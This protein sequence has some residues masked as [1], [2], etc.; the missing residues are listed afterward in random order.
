MPSSFTPAW[1][2]NDP[3][4]AGWLPLD[5][6]RQADRG[7]AVQAATAHSM[8]AGLVDVIAAQQARLPA[9]QARDRA[10]AALRNPDAMA[11]VTGQQV[12]LFLGP[13]YTLYK[14]ASTVRIAR[15][16]ADETGLPCVPIFWLQNE[17]HD[18]E[19]I[20]RIELPTD[21][22]PVSLG[23]ADTPGDVLADADDAR[24]W[25]LVSVRARRLGG[26]VEQLH[27]QLGPHL[28]GLPCGADV[29][30]LLA[31][32]YQSDATLSAAFAGVLAELFA[33]QGLLIIDPSDAALTPFA[34]PVHRKA[35]GDAAAMAASLGE[36]SAALNRAGVAVQVHVRPDSPLSFWHCGDRDGPRY[37]LEPQGAESWRLCGSQATV[38]RST[39][40]HDLKHRPERFSTSALLRP[41]LQDSWLPT[42]AYVGGPG[43]CAYFAQL[44][45]LY[46]AFERQMPLVVPRAR[47]ALVDATAR[48]LAR[49][50]GLAPCDAQDSE[51]ALLARLGAKRLEG[52]G[53]GDDSVPQDLARSL[54]EPL[55]RQL[56]RLATD[57]DGWDPGLARSTRRL[58]KALVAQIEKFA[59]RYQRAVG[60][61]DAT[62]RQRLARLQGLLSPDGLPQE[63]RYGFA[64]FAARV[65]GCQL[66]AQ[67]VAHAEPWQH[68]LKWLDL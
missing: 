10:V 2:A 12:G 40:L 17:D 66:V 34:A 32:H 19:E 48:R 7:R 63:R 61:R 3:A 65:G 26:E 42:V 35:F 30:A 67:L 36:R 6:R 46:E 21:A 28:D 4:A 9:C 31:R 39:V 24:D 59:G 38:A 53:P 55:R 25:G 15:A 51:A 47:F 33:G 56:A 58:E 62:T 23:L 49:Q 44:A 52:D 16:L 18:F 5:F 8:P 27:G 54:H 45:P 11:V 50:L 37:R 41:L 29:A 68:E 60:G 43:E 22:G 14:A 13:L 20:R 57:A 1:L 64:T